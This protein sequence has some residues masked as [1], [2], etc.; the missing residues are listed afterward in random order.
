[1]GLQNYL[2]KCSCK[3]CGLEFEN[4][5]IL[6]NHVRWKHKD[7]TEFLKRLPLILDGVSNKNW[8]KRK[9][10]IIKIDCKCKRC[11]T[12]FKVKRRILSTRKKPIFCSQACSLLY[13]VE[14]RKPETNIKISKKLKG[15]RI[16]GIIKTFE[17]R[18]CECCKIEFQIE[19]Y[20][21]KR[22]CSLSCSI[23]FRNKKFN[24]LKHEKL[25]YRSKCSFKF[26]LNEYPNEFDFSLIEK[27]GWYKAKN[28]GDNL[29]GIS[30]D[31][32][33]SIS[34]GFKNNIDP[35]ILSHP[36]NCELKI[37]SKNISKGYKSSITLENLMIRI[38]NWNEKYG[39]VAERLGIP[40]Q[41]VV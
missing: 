28:N 38:S 37:H 5:R 35:N 41:K 19:P 21:R 16:G 40:L 22:F 31:H 26:A 8:E 20:K 27:H 3:I 25:N 39:Q 17:I 24:D 9:G 12:V 4:K 14:N 2:E 11:E 34:D 10:K 23:R 30:R 32:M 15:R 7:Q 18:N 1:M 13:L 36:A 29:G 6:A 33:Y